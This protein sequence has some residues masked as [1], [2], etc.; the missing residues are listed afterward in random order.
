MTRVL[1]GLE[2]PREGGRGARGREGADQQSTERSCGVRREEG[3]WVEDC[4]A[5]GRH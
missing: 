1:G 5:P 4:H 2:R 3:A